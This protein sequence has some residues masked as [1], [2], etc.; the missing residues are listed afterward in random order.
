MVADTLG[1]AVHQDVVVDAVEELWQSSRLP[2]AVALDAA[3]RAAQFNRVQGMHE[4]LCLTL[5]RKAVLMTLAGRP[6]PAR[7]RLDRAGAWRSRTSTGPLH[8]DAGAAGGRGGR[9]ARPDRKRRRAVPLSVVGGAPRRVHHVGPRRD[10]P[11]ERW[12]VEQHATAGAEFRPGAGFEWPPGRR[13]AHPGR[14]LAGLAAPRDL[15]RLRHHVRG[16]GLA[17]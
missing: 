14:S 12:I 4:R 1:H 16:A 11:R 7:T 6:A 2:L 8:G 15:R 13:P 9:W 5:T 17:P 10:R 3:D